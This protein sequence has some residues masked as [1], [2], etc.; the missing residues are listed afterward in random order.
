MDMKAFTGIMLAKTSTIDRDFS[1]TSLFIPGKWPSKDS[2]V[3]R[4]EHQLMCVESLN[5]KAQR[6]F[7]EF[8]RVGR[9]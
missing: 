2:N 3:S 5:C 4:R 1:I 9:E 6:N 8:S 7:L